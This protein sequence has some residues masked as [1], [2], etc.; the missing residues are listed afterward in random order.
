MLRPRRAIP[1]IVAGLCGAAVSIP[2]GH[3]VEP[4]PSQSI[5]PS[6][7]IVSRLS[8]PRLPSG[9]RKGIRFEPDQGGAPAPSPEG[10]ARVEL[11]A[12]QFEYDSA[13]LTYQARLQLDELA[14]ALESNDLRPF[15]FSVQG[16]TD[17][18]GSDAYNRALS[19]R[20]A[21]AVK[22]HLV[23][24]GN[25][26]PGRLIE[27]GL[28]ESFP[29]LPDAPADERNR[30]VEFVN[31]GKAEVG[32]GRVAGGRRALLIGIDAYR[33]V[34]P[35]VG[36]VNDA[37]AMKSFLVTHLGYD[38]RNVRMLLN[39]EATRGAILATVEDWLIGGTAAGDEVFVYFSG[40][41][42]QQPDT[43]G[44]EADRLDETL[45]PVDVAVTEGGTITGM[46]T[47]DELAERLT[48][49]AGRR[50]HVVIDACHSG[51][52][53]RFA[54][55]HESWRYVK[56]PRRPNGGPIRIAAPAAVAPAIQRTGVAEA[57][58][59]RFLSSKDPGMSRLDLTVWSAVKAEQKALVDKESPPGEP[60]SVFT[61]RMLWGVRDGRA[62]RDRDGVVTRAELKDYLV[63]ESEAYCERHADH[64]PAG[65]TPQLHATS[66]RLDRNA[67]AGT[68]E[69]L[70]SSPSSVAVAKDILVRSSPGA[71]AGDG[72]GIGLR[73][74]PGTSL[75]VGEELDI[76]VESDRD[77]HLVLLD[78]DAA[79]N[80]MQIFPNE[81]S[82]RS[83]VPDRIQAG[84]PM[85][86]PG[87]RAGF[88]FR[89]TAPT[90]RG[91]LIA[92]VS[93]EGV[94]LRGLVSR[95]KDLSVVPRP[96]AYLVE[97][98][99]AL[100][101]IGDGPRRVGTLGYEVVAP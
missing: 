72:G 32:T 74:E 66:S 55:E 25:V 51:T 39:S 84:C 6:Q 48:R 88:R 24:E 46:I 30:R 71:A 82:L 68:F 21:R 31:L 28:G 65:L 27:V 35:L 33:E 36:P 93:G 77:G 91:T 2:A 54:V 98:G 61:R 37:R 8:P 50:V 83:G 10:P 29:V 17:S 22:R 64:C 79:G 11:S 89:A 43:N 9:R 75:A 14:D 34:F 76:V 62:D 45:V 47:D 58:P 96:E 97:L 63:R 69:P 49:L 78:I 23:A 44:D 90:G 12:V 38:D 92:V 18:I 3:A 73:I 1:V 20:R 41:G 101:A 15:Y 52:G 53:T 13:R 70:P 19:L 86:L 59:E 42:F 60:G 94:E 4:V 56:S 40:H 5:V 80:M 95:H 67:F 85:R 87:D 57:Q 99:E 16:H 100:Q 26:S 81:P 7:D